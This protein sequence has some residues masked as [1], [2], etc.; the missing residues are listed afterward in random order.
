M[1][2]CNC[3]TLIGGQIA[4][5]NIDDGIESNVPIS[6]FLTGGSL[7]RTGLITHQSLGKPSRGGALKAS[8]LRDVLKSGYKMPGEQSQNIDGY[9][10]DD[11]LSGRRSQVYHNPTTGQSII[12]HRGT[13][14]TLADWKNNLLYA[15][16]LYKHTNRYKHAKDAQAKAEAKYGAKNLSTI[17]HSQGAM[18]A[19]EVGK[20]SKESISLDRPANLSALL[21]HKTGKNHH[22]VRTNTDVVSS[23]IPLQ[24]QSNKTTTIKAGSYNPL[25]SHDVGQLDKLGDTMIGSGIKNKTR[26]VRK[27]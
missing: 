9:V 10:R 17:G 15:T 22:D 27:K 14:G 24:K 4:A 12:S 20:N 23:M 13:E 26:K 6:P 3:K 25:K 11:A 8:T 2:P 7:T 16:G 21:T 5:E 18:L 1:Y 19:E